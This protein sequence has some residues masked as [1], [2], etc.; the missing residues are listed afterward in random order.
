MKKRDIFDDVRRKTWLITWG[1]CAVIWALA[2][3]VI[4]W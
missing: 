2:I 3:I 1:G 4:I